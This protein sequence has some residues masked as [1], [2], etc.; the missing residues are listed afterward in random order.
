MQKIIE[1]FEA[2]ISMLDFTLNSRKKRHIAERIMISMSLLFG[3]LT[4]TVMTIKDEWENI[5]E[6]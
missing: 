5:Y 2:T 6:K 3:G 4:I 1:L